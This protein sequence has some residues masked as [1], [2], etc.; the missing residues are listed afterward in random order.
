VLFFNDRSDS[1]HW[2]YVEL[3]PL[4]GFEENE[5]YAID[6]DDPFSIVMRVPVDTSAPGFLRIELEDDVLGPYNDTK[7]ITNPIYF[8]DWGDECEGSARMR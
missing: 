1:S 5:H 4:D 3:E 6:P 2:F 7:T 8:G